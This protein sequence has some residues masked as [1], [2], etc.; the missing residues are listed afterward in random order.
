MSKTTISR[1]PKDRDTADG[2]RIIES[3][4]ENLEARIKELEQWKKEQ[5]G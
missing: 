4:I 1:R 2:F 5:G 3:I